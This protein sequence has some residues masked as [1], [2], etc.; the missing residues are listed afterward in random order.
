VETEDDVNIQIRRGASFSGALV[1]ETGAV[2]S[3]LYTLTLPI[4]AGEYSIYILSPTVNYDGV[5][6]LRIKGAYFKSASFTELTGL[7]ELSLDQSSVPQSHNIVFNSLNIN[8]NVLLEKLEVIHH[9]LSSINLTVND[10][11]EYIDVSY[12]ENLISLTIGSWSVLKVLKIHEISATKLGYT[13]AFINSI[14]NTFNASVPIS[15]TGYVLQYGVN[16]LSGVVPSNA[17]RTAYDSLIS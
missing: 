2:P 6:V 15:S 16:N 7:V 13:P 3:G 12:G 17:A 8:S 14:I 9:K 4:Y 11:L 10:K 1:T 5:T